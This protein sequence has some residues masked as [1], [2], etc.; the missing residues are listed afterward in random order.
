MLVDPYRPVRLYIILYRGR[1]RDAS[2]P[3]LLWLVAL[4]RGPEGQTGPRTCIRAWG[5]PPRALSVPI[6]GAFACSPHGPRFGGLCLFR[7]GAPRALR[8]PFA[9]SPF[10]SPTARDAP[11]R[12][13]FSLLSWLRASGSFMCGTTQ[14]LPGAGRLGAQVLGIHG[15]LLERPS[16]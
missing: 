6:S 10:L 3:I 13:H 14:R 16:M 7:R 12:G 2:P 15:G 5:G 11:S 8:R 9:Q 4:Y 1:D